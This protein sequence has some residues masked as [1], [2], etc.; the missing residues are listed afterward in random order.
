MQFKIEKMILILNDHKKRELVFHDGVNIISGKSQTGKSALIDIIDYC[1]FSSNC[2]I[3]QGVISQSVNIYCLVLW[4]NNKRLILARNRYD[5]DKN[6]GRS[7]I[8]LYEINEFFNDSSISSDFFETNKERYIS[9]AQFKD[10]HIKNIVNIFTQKTQLDDLNDSVLSFRSMTSFMFQHQNLMA[11]KYALFYRLDSF[12]RVKQTQRDLKI[13][14]DIQDIKFLEIEDRLD[15]INK[16]LKQIEKEEKFINKKFNMLINELKNDCIYYYATLG[17]SSDKILLISNFENSDILNYE[18]IVSEIKNYSINSN[19]PEELSKIEKEKDKLFHKINQLTMQIEDIKSY[20]QDLSS[21]QEILDIKIKVDTEETCPLCNSTHTNNIEK[22]I[23]AKEKIQAESLEIS[24]LSP[25]IIEEKKLL[26]NSLKDEKEDFL[27]LKQKYKYMKNKYENII[28]E[29]GKKEELLKLKT[30]IISQQKFLKDLKKFNN[31]DKERLEEEQRT[32]KSKKGNF[33]F[34]TKLKQIEVK[35]SEYINE[36]INNGLELERALGKPDLYFSI[37]DFSLYQK[38]KFNKRI[39]L[40]E[41]GSGS[42]W[43]NCHISLMLGLHKYIAFNNSKIPSF[44]FFDQPS[45]VYFPSDKDIE[46]GENNKDSDLVT[47]ENIFKKIIEDV[48]LINEDKECKSKIQLFITDHYFKNEPW[49]KKHLIEDGAWTE[50]KKLIPIEY[51]N[52]NI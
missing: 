48:E 36:I 15:V 42:N 13:Y 39:Y 40:S 5:S 32:L 49:F 2:T 43:L 37:D 24:T 25:K 17:N 22:Y 45:Q 19:I 8:F 34:K 7:K 11:N 28:T 50:G 26:E 14:M 10:L 6:P 23:K 38:A 27:E 33:D 1:L 4:I 12:S 51:E 16:E 30:K 31:K 18:E 35:I 20:E 3:P 21:T 46:K 41:M 47:V 9:E 52:N 29:E 44:I